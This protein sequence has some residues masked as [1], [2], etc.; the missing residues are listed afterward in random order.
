MFQKNINSQRYA[1]QIMTSHRAYGS[2]V[3]AQNANQDPLVQNQEIFD[4]EFWNTVQH[5]AQSVI[6]S[7]VYD[8]VRMNLLEFLGLVKIS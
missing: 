1:F 7:L 6:A 5:L 3:N 8:Y 4:N 2:N